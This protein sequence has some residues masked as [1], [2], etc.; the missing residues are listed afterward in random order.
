MESEKSTSALFNEINKLIS[1]QGV[2]KAYLSIKSL[3]RSEVGEDVAAFDFIVKTVVKSFGVT[4]AELYDSK[5]KFGASDARKAC[6]YLIR[7]YLNYSSKTIAMQFNKGGSTVREG[8]I[9]VR[10]MLK[11]GD[12]FHKEYLLKHRDVEEQVGQYMD[13]VSKGR[14]EKQKDGEED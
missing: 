3:N 1:K 2:N 8:I 11:D 14:K 6:Y 9:E 10:T 4:K 5:D 7:K 12:K 13:E